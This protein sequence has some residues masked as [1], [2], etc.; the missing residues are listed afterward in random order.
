MNKIK[1]GTGELRVG[2]FGLIIY[3]PALWVGEAGRG[4]STSE[5]IRESI[6]ASCFVFT[7]AFLIWFICNSVF[8]WDVFLLNEGLPSANT[9]D[10]LIDYDK[11]NTHQGEPNG[12]RDISS[13]EQR[14]LNVKKTIPTNI[15]SHKDDCDTGDEN[16]DTAGHNHSSELEKFVNLC[17]RLTLL[18][19][20]D[21]SRREG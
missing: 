4:P 21:K 8:K 10:S 5:L 20:S 7:V 1:L 16:K 14:E 18:P 13:F 3:L 17:K 11:A 19:P 12:E 2:I 9:L 6:S 15:R